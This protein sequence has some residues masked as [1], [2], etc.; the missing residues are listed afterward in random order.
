MD[1]MVRGAASPTIP[2]E[3]CRVQWRD[4]DFRP[5]SAWRSG[6]VLFRDEHDVRLGPDGLRRFFWLVDLGIQLVFEPFEWRDEWVVDVVT[7][8]ERRPGLLHVRDMALDVIVEGMGPTYRMLDLD[9]VA[10]R[11]SSGAFSIEEAGDVLTRAETFVDTYLHRNG[12]WPPPQICPFFSAD[13]RYPK[14]GDGQ[15]LATR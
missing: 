15:V 14:V 4:R 10:R 13:H 6:T 12:P 9:D 1:P 7:I 3:R 5:C 2:L 11:L 8:T